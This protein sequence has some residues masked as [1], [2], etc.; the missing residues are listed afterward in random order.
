MS[1][2]DLL[3]TADA[4]FEKEFGQTPKEHGFLKSAIYN[5]CVIYFPTQKIII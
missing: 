4:E 5:G 1:E 3:K 2:K